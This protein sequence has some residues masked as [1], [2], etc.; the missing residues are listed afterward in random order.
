MRAV[1]G[2]EFH[3][4]LNTQSK[5]FSPETSSTGRPNMAVHPVSRGVPGAMPFLNAAMVEK[6][7][8]MALYC[9]SEITSVLEFDRKHY[10]YPDL[11]KGY[12]ITQYRRPLAREGFLPVL[13]HGYEM[14]LNI[15]IQ[16][17][18]LEEDSAKTTDRKQDILIDL[19]RAGIPLLELVTK[20]EIHEPEKASHTLQFVQK[21]VRYL[22][23]SDGN[24]E[25]GSLRCDANISIRDEQGNSSPRLEV[26]NLNSAA[27]L[28]MALKYEQKRLHKAW[29][30]EQ[31]IKA[32]TRFYDDHRKETISGREK[33]TA[34]EY[35]YLPEWDLLPVKI[36]KTMLDRVKNNLPPKIEE[37]FH[38]L[39]NQY[40][41]A[42]KTAL[43][44]SEDLT[45]LRIFQNA[46]NRRYSPKRIAN[47][48]TN[49]IRNLPLRFENPK[50]AGITIGELAGMVDAKQISEK[51]AREILPEL[52]AHPKGNI[53]EFIRQKELFLQ[54]NS[55][56]LINLVEKIIQS[57]PKE[58][59]KYRSGKKSVLGYFM[60]EA[61]KRSGGTIDPQQAKELIEQ[62]LN[63]N[64]H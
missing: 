42:V 45:S 11:P 20:A 61:M 12:Q 64:E 47:W 51:A 63:K 39:C 41:L 55:K 1:I 26:K 62:K 50:A 56:Y 46:V 29:N 53:E 40:Q 14:P 59:E 37:S 5:A 43:M 49:I 58:V 17:M 34:G 16:E 10:F 32:E 18:H 33:E 25:N 52:I 7:L 30:S 48:L 19:N 35:R 38:N 22:D 31:T 24:M 57:S 28:K 2:L 36:E 27:A 4:Q 9:H 44:I 15:G 3:I 8:R 13:A 23:I 6:G 54:K 60:G 21:L